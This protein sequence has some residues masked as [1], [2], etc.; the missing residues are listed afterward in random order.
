MNDYGVVLETG[1][2]RFERVLPGPIE[3][4]WAY[5]TESDKRGKWFAAGDMELRAGGKLEFVFRNTDLSADKA[6]PEKYKQ[7]EGLR[8]DG[9]ITRCEPPRLL[10]FTWGE[11][12]PAPDSEVT[13]ELSPRGKDVL[14]V[15]THRRLADRKAMLGVSGGWHSHL[16]ILEDQLNGREPRPFW[17]THTRLEAE[18]QQRFGA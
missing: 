9:R 2:V 15:L 10:S 8:T 12:P 7:Y 14:L 3:R 16:G 1:T 13:F 18:Y 5:L 6:T 11:E 17:S 4:V